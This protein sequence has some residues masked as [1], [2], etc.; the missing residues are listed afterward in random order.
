MIE[1]IGQYSMHYQGVNW[2]M[3]EGKEFCLEVKP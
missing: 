3:K 1:H 2:S